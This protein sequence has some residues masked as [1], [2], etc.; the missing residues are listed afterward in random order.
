A[1]RRAISSPP[2]SGHEHHAA[3]L[4]LVRVLRRRLRHAGCLAD[5]RYDLPRPGCL[6]V[7]AH[8]HLM[9]ALRAPFGLLSQ[10][11]Q[12]QTPVWF[13]PAAEHAVRQT[14]GKRRLY[15]CSKV[16]ISSEAATEFG[17][18]TCRLLMS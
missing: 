12:Q 17:T 2:P 16:P 13:A 15:A 7:P 5:L 3:P 14:Y 11:R 1:M 9:A 18:S 6:R 10:Q 8:G 4:L